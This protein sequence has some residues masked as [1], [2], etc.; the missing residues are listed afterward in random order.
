MW[1][2]WWWWW[3]WPILFALSQNKQGNGNVCQLQTSNWYKIHFCRKEYV[4]IKHSALTILHAWA[5]WS[6]SGTCRTKQANLA[7][8]KT[9]IG[10]WLWATSQQWWSRPAISQRDQEQ[11][12]GQDQDQWWQS[13]FLSQQFDRGGSS[14]RQDVQLI[15]WSRPLWPPRRASR[16]STRD[17]GPLGAARARPR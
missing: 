13:G 15:S 3:W 7:G 14:T 12:W 5:H 10:S 8:M 2:W 11:R 9:L 1:W 6:V 16:T 17:P 4:S